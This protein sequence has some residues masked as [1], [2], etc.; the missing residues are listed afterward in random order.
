MMNVILRGDEESPP[1]HDTED[2][3]EQLVLFTNGRMLSG[4]VSRNGGGYL[5]EQANGRIQVPADDVKF[6]AKDL[7]DAYRKQRDSIVEPTPATHLALANWCISHRLL[8]EANDELKKCLNA[9][10]ENQEARRLLQRLTDSFR[11][12]LPPKV[13]EPMPLK[14]VDG[15][16]QPEVESLGGLSKETAAQFTS[17]VQPLLLNKCGNA[18][19]H[20]STSTNPFKLTPARLG[21]MG[22][23]QNTERN[24]AETLKYLDMEDVASSHLLRATKGSHGGKGTIFIGPAGSDQMKQLREWALTV[25]KEK[26]AKDEEFN[27]HKERVVDSSP[28]KRNQKIVQAGHTDAE[29][30]DGAESD[31]AAAAPTNDLDESAK[32]DSARPRLLKPVP[33]D[34]KALALEPDDAFNPEDFN[35]RFRR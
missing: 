28:K 3:R 25:A 13:V 33:N 16:L 22:S 18:S 8:D 10:P 15:F 32:R 30:K 26:H 34:A 9:D 2:T 11:T 29:A 35:R 6:V 27:R 31:T 24:L 4:R 23:R 20:G 12:N 19:C 7:R 14:T 5:I 17:R 21:S 1:P